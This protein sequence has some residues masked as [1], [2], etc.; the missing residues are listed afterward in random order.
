MFSATTFYLQSTGSCGLVFRQTLQAVIA[1]T[2]AMQAYSSVSLKVRNKPIAER[3]FHHT[4][5]GN[6]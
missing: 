5:K 6:I 4:Q 3:Q 2:G 1:N